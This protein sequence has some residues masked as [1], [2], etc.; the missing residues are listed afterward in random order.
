MVRT[1]ISCCYKIQL[2]YRWNQS[3]LVAC[4][5]TMHPYRQACTSVIKLWYTAVVPKLMSH[6]PP[7]EPAAGQFFLKRVALLQWQQ[8]C[9]SNCSS[10]AAKGLF[11]LPGGQHWAPPG[12]WRLTI[13]SNLLHKAL[14]S[15][16]LLLPKLEI[17]AMQTS[18]VGVQKGLRTSRTL[19]SLQH[20][21]CPLPSPYK[22]LPSRSLG[23]TN[24]QYCIS[25]IFLFTCRPHSAALGHLESWSCGS[26]LPRLCAS[27]DHFLP[28]PSSAVL[29]PLPK[30]F[31]VQ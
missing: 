19:Q 26:F 30:A 7:G 12:F 28:N 20:G 4:L 5:P 6:V 24:I 17:R 31:T 16:L 18:S 22:Q 11:H 2:I 3:Q 25:C 23:T 1:L 15:Y 8:Q 9:C 14:V 27:S 29:P 13:P 10:A 21:C